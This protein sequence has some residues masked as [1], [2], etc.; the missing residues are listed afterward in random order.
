MAHEF[1]KRNKSDYIKENTKRFGNTCI[2][3]M[4]FFD[5]GRTNYEFT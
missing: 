2:L 4:I 1:K 5:K 3:Q